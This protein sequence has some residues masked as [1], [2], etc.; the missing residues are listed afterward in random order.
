MEKGK[1]HA[2]GTFDDLMFRSKEFSSMVTRNMSEETV[3]CAK[4]ISDP[5]VNNE[6]IGGKEQEEVALMREEERRAKSVSR[7][8]WLDYVKAG[9]GTWAALLA[10]AS[11]VLSQLSNLVAG[12]WLSFWIHNKFGFSEGTNICFYAAIGLIQ[13]VLIFVS[14]LTV[15][16]FATGASKIMLHR[17]IA[18]VLGAPV[19]FFD[20]TPLG[21]IMSRFSRD[22]FIMDESLTDSIR[23]VSTSLVMLVCN[24]AL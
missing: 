10:V 13:A 11:V 19:S 22:V 1:V 8:V 24:C 23:M 20:T 5:E 6:K 2:V 9:G 14:Y 7:R 18:R 12:L 16:S 15:S 17:A 21:R 4:E 3:R